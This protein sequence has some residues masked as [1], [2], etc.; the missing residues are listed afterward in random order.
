LGKG[1]Y[2]TLKT[3]PY[4]DIPEGSGSKY[5][6][7]GSHSHQYGSKDFKLPK[8][9]FPK[10]SGE[11]PR[12]WKERCEKYFSMY[13]VPVHMWVPFATMNFRKN[14]ALWVQTYEAQ[15]NIDSW[16]ELCVAVEHKFGRDMYQNYMRDMLSI[17]QTSDVLEYADRF[18]QARHGVLGTIA[19]L[20]KFS[21][22]KNSLMVSIIRSAIPLLYIGRELLMRLYPLH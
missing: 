19:K 17:K 2:T 14:A 9:D 1:E 22:S 12:V 10:F 8:L 13:S 20:M 16:A 3:A 11:H 4:T 15:H 21:L 7:F 6:G 18:E 5:T